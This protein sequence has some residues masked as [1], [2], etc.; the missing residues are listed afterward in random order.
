MR[1]RRAGLL[2]H[3]T[4]TLGRI[5][6]KSGGLYPASKWAAEGLAESLYY[7][8]KPFGIDVTILEPGTFPTPAISKGMRPAHAAVAEAYA[9]VAAPAR[10]SEPGPDYVPPDPQDVADA[11][12]HL[13]AMPAGERPLRYVVGPIFTEG[14]AEYN[15]AYERA[16]DAL[17]ESLLRPDQAITWGR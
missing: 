12:L 5:L 3:V 7:Q 8:V 1:Q 13:A 11:V 10:R 2:I 6:P 16:R 15:A 17:A 14:V 9:A 4:S